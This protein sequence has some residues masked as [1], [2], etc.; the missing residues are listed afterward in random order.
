[1]DATAKF[2]TNAISVAML[3]FGVHA[4]K[5]CGERFSNFQRKSISNH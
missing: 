4:I 3:N 1:M 5:D 2:L